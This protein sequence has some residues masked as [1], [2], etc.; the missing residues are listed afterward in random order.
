MSFLGTR[1]K[2]YASSAGTQPG[3]FN[4][5]FNSRRAHFEPAAAKCAVISTDIRRVTLAHQHHIHPVDGVHVASLGKI[6]R[7]S[8]IS[9]PNLAGSDPGWWALFR[10]LVGA[11]CEP[12]G[13]VRGGGAGW[14]KRVRTLYTKGLSAFT[15]RYKVCL[16]SFSVSVTD[17][18]CSPASVALEPA[19]NQPLT[20]PW[21][22]QAGC[23]IRS[24][25]HCTYQR[26]ALEPN[27]PDIM[28]RPGCQRAYYPRFLSCSSLNDAVSQR[29][30]PNRTLN[31]SQ[32]TSIPKARSGT[33]LVRDALWFHCST[34]VGCGWATRSFIALP[35]HSTV[36]LIIL[37]PKPRRT[38]ARQSRH[39]FIYLLNLLVH[40][41]PREDSR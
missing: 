34:P 28:L 7:L 21:N 5:T 11:L 31:L 41:R 3:P 6:A 29:A 35:L 12:L 8:F 26:S 15:C 10:E 33:R 18:R 17:C 32:P 30:S 20:L 16:V 27:I 25:L 38:T 2:G 13:E 39:R 24:I 36:V 37:Q 23:Y 14:Q 40:A 19:T 22:P 9:V 4:A 1:A